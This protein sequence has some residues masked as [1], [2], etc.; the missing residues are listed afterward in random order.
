[1][2]FGLKN[3]PL[4]YQ[5]VI[6]N[7]LW[8]FVRLPPEEEAEVDQEVLDYLNL[9]PQDDR[10]P[11]CGTPGCSGCEN[12]HAPRSLPTLANQM[13]VLKRNIPTPTQMSPVRGRSSYI[14]DIA[15]GAPT[16]D[17][18][19]PKSEFGKLSIPYLSHDVS[20]EGI[21]A[22]PKIAKGVQ[23]LPFLTAM[24]GVQSFL[25]SQNYYH[26]FIEDYPVIAAS[27]YE[28][29]DDQHKIVSTPV[30]R[31]PDRTKPFVIIP[32]PN[33]WAACV[34]LS[35]EHDGLVQPVRF[36][37]L[38]YYIAEKEVITV[39]RVLQVFK[40]LIQG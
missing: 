18:F 29:S 5:Q 37:E 10:P 21:R 7:C 33:Q 39:L 32:H 38:R 30:L 20:A 13:T 24:K 1:M 9:D 17:A 22:T 3:A 12:A 2:P 14:D 6:D 23:D 27:L 36:T 11:G 28:L 40:T 19:L 4:M 8:G 25:D 15:H 34:V 16:W 26:K 35:H 31:H